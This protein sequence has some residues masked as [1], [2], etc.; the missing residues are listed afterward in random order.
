MVDQVL[1]IA[2]RKS[3][4]RTKHHDGYFEDSCTNILK[5]SKEIIVLD[6]GGTKF[7]VLKAM[8]ATWPSTRLYIVNNIIIL[9]IL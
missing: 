4:R 1:G 8:F 9:F 6:V 7:Y 2:L 5:K 3:V